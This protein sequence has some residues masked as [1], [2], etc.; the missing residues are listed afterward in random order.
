MAIKEGQISV[1][2][3]AGSDLSDKQFHFVSIAADGQV[4]V[5]GAGELAHGVLL[6][7]PAAAG[8]AAEVAVGGDT[9]VTAGGTVAAGVSVA[10]DENG[11]AVAATSGDERLGIAVTGGAAGEI[12]T[13][14]YM[15]HGVAA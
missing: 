4:D 1:T 11:N 12:I 3:Q 6:N 2:R 7:D 8:R 9:R 10:S 13:I 15:P 5:T 14:T